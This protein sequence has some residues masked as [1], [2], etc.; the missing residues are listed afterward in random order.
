MKTLII[1]GIPDSFNVEI[2][3]REVVFGDLLSEED[4][5]NREYSNPQI[6][7]GV[8]IDLLRETL[9]Q[10]IK[11]NKN[12]I[13]ESITYYESQKKLI[14][15]SNKEL[16]LSVV[17]NDV[18]KNSIEKVSSFLEQLTFIESNSIQNIEEYISVYNLLDILIFFVNQ[19]NRISSIEKNCENYLRKQNLNFDSFNIEYEDYLYND[20]TRVSLL[21]KVE[22]QEDYK[23]LIN[24][25]LMLDFYNSAADFSS[26]FSEI[27]KVFDI[28]DNIKIFMNFN[29]KYNVKTNIFG[30]F[31]SFNNKEITCRNENFGLK[32][33]LSN[34]KID[35]FCNHYK[36]Y[37][38][39]QTN[40]NDILKNVYIEIRD[41]PSFVKEK[42]EK[43][44]QKKK[45]LF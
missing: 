11:N 16:R 31:L 25:E 37:K 5:F 33:D 13:I 18:D 28:L 17:E 42:I 41:C 21:I 3:N 36:D 6:L 26:N 29:D 38:Y 19:L 8:S 35:F 27:H 4:E 32:I 23:Y 9:N 10:N 7:E 34:N 30:T 15:D 14:I 20:F 40:V 43:T 12:S 39:L 22:G 2:I 45:S 44:K 24:K 1:V